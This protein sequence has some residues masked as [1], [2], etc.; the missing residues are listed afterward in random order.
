[1]QPNEPQPLVPI[2]AGAEASTSAARG[3]MP[4]T[5]RRQKLAEA[6]GQLELSVSSA[7]AGDLA[8]I[9]SMLAAQAVALNAVFANLT[10]L[11]SRHRLRDL[12]LAEQYLRIAM[13]A[14]NQA[15]ATLEAL[16][17]IV[18]PRASVMVQTNVV[19][20]AQPRFEPLPDSI[21]RAIEEISG[22]AQAHVERQPNDDPTQEGRQ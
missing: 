11:A 21:R 19:N 8:P 9:K 4:K 6:V 12:D 7:Q 10:Q 3:W 22:A 1:M 5:D 20:G 17:D 13:R 15:R 14:Q 2:D 16:T 18:S